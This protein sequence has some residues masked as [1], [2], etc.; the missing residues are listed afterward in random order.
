M[1]GAD[2]KYGEMSTYQRQCTN[3]NRAYEVGLI[4]M[5]DLKFHY[6]KDVLSFRPALDPLQKALIH[7]RA[8]SMGKDDPLKADYSKFQTKKRRRVTTNVIPLEHGHLT[9][10]SDYR[11]TTMMR[12]AKKLQNIYRGKQ[13]RKRANDLAKRDAFYNARDIAIEEMKK[14]VAAEFE[15]RENQG[16]V[17]KMKWDANVRKRQITLRASG[18]H[19]DRDGVVGL[20]MDDAIRSGTDEIKARFHEL[21]VK[22]GFEEK[23]DQ[24]PEEDDDSL[25]TQLTSLAAAKKSN[26]FKAIFKRDGKF[27]HFIIFFILFIG[28]LFEWERTSLRFQQPHSCSCGAI[29]L[30][31]ASPRL[32]L[33]QLAPLPHRKFKTKTK[34]KKKKRIGNTQG[35]H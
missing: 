1:F 15:K 5:P 31:P 25:L 16:G 11:S 19:F 10:L 9:N 4:S 6:A 29:S 2:W 34:R 32:L 35:R 12:A 8:L 22:M 24:K 13:A 17:A 14:K 30:N 33:L 27:I 26:V 21:A 20:L 3:P 7:E 23:V 28:S 18:K